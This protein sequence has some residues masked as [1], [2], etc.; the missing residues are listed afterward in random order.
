M[1]PFTT[2]LPSTAVSETLVAPLVDD[3]EVKMA[4]AVPLARV[5]AWPV[6]CRLTLR[7]VRV[8]N[9]VPAFEAMARA[10]S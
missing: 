6:P 3:T 7:T 10:A 1:P 9:G 2:R 8:P 4:S 5:S